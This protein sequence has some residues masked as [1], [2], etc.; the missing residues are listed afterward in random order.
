[1]R[2]LKEQFNAKLKKNATS[3]HN[4]TFEYFSQEGYRVFSNKNP[5]D[6]NKYYFYCQGK[7]IHKLDI[8][9]LSEIEKVVCPECGIMDYLKIQDTDGKNTRYVCKNKDKHISKETILFRVTL[10]IQ[11][12]TLGKLMKSIYNV[13]IQEYRD[14]YSKYK[15]MYAKHQRIKIEDDDIKY[16]EHYLLLGIPR[17]LIAELFSINTRTLRRFIKKEESLETLEKSRFKKDALIT[18]DQKLKIQKIIYHPDPF[19]SEILYTSTD[20]PP[21]DY[22]T[23]EDPK[24]CIDK[25]VTKASKKINTPSPHTT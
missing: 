18:A 24:Y 3:K 15:K 23:Y 17:K 7:K 4:I 22:D 11:T 1:M 12:N 9:N 14:T 16:L 21:V 8:D 20:S 6:N 5:H 19:N 10:P 25:T 13:P 2:T